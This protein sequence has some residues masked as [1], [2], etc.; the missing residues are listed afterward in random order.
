MNSVDDSS[1]N[2][3]QIV[4]LLKQAIESGAQVAFL[5][6]NCLYMRIKEGEAIAGLTLDDKNIQ[7]LAEFAKKFGIS[8]H[9]G[10]VPLLMGKLLYNSSVWISA[11]GGIEPTYQKIHLF[12]IAL[13]GQNPIRES[14]VFTHGTEP[15]ILRFAGWSMGQ[16]ICYDIRFAELF[17]FYAKAHVD[18]LLVPAAFLTKT[19]EAHW[20][21]LLRARAIE[22]QTYV[23]AAAQAGVHHSR[24]G[25][26]RE[27]YGR[28]MVIDPWG[29]ILAEA[30]DHAP[31][32]L[33]LELK[34]QELDY[35]R[36][37]IPMKDHR[38]L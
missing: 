1:L 14:D 7:L 38:R 20:E 25:A 11:D 15:R 35:V 28:S 26:F 36:R 19:G 17:N 16:T 10:S 23:I 31:Q 3:T 18:M 37:Q 2:L 32:V 21:V 4:G 9:L 8:V 30:K 29:R 13:K 24:S 27:T 34:R 12:D 6:E 5:P 33:V 22:S